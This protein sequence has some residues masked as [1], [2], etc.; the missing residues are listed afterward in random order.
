MNIPEHEK[1]GMK[2][3]YIYNE[4]SPAAMENMIWPTTASIIPIFDAEL[5]S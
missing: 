5:D 3:L 4:H 1:N 2:L